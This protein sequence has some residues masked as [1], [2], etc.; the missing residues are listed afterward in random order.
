MAMIKYTERMTL[1]ETDIRSIRIER[2]IRQGDLAKMANISPSEL[3]KYERGLVPPDPD[4]IASISSILSVSPD[5][6]LM[7]HRMMSDHPASGEGYVTKNRNRFFMI[8]RRKT[9]DNSRVP[10]LDLFCGT[11]GFSSGF[12]QTGKFQV[13]AG[14]DLMPD[15]INTFSFNH[16]AANAYCHDIAKFQLSEFE[17]DIAPQVIIGGPPC[18]GFT[19]IR[20]FRSVSENDP[21]NNLFVHFTLA[22]KRI[23]PKWF[24]LENVV[25]LSTHQGGKTLERLYTMFREIGY[26]VSWSILNTVHFGLPQRRERLIMVGN[27]EGR[28]FEFP[29]PTH[30]FVGRSMVKNGLRCAGATKAGLKPPVTVMDAIGDLPEVGAAESASKYGRAVT[31]Y[32]RMMRLDSTRLKLHSATA[33][34]ERMLAIIRHSGSNRSAI[35]KGMVTSGFSTSYSRLDPDEPS[36]TITANFA[37]PGSNKCVHPYQDRALTPREAARLQGFRDNYEFMGNRTEILKQIG[38]AVPPILGRV[39]GEAVLRQARL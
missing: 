11:G 29:E 2:G 30:H 33:H 8:E 13:V 24:V 39:I 35:P 34:S 22:V 14:L 17:R 16:P 5:A 36:V 1:Q 31:L 15:R 28:K 21:R 10:V 3:S 25:G 27:S 4:T 6:L 7:T 32:Q 19:S 37:F 20:P 18:Q 26:A 38:N 9:P 12:E 23:M